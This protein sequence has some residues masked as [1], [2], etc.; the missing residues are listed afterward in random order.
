MFWV[1]FISLKIV[2]MGLKNLYLY[3]NVDF[4]FKFFYRG[5]GYYIELVKDY[6]GIRFLVKCEL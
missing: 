4:F 1:I 3:L 6:L 2:D 5:N